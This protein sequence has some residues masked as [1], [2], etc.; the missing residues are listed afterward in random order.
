MGPADPGRRSVLQPRSA[1]VGRRPEGRSGTVPSHERERHAWLSSARRLATVAGGLAPRAERRERR[2]RV[3]Q[4][5]FFDAQ[6][7]RGKNLERVLTESLSRFALTNF[8]VP[9]YGLMCTT[10]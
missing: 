10:T 1:G 3:S 6:E 2:G 7:G 9:S 4:R 8:I 5:P